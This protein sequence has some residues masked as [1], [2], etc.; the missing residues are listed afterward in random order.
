MWDLDVYSSKL[1]NES[2]LPPRTAKVIFE[3]GTI[4]PANA[5][6]QTSR[7]TRLIYGKDDEGF[8]RQLLSFP[9][10][11][12]ALFPA[13]A[14][15]DGKTVYAL[16]DRDGSNQAIVRVNRNLSSPELIYQHN[17]TDVMGYHSDSNREIYAVDFGVGQSELHFLNPDHADAKTLRR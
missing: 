2:V 15:R 7:G 1:K 3:E 11:G 14:S 5:N 4:R 8:W 9:S 17:S 10:P 6:G 16:D 13:V 12:G